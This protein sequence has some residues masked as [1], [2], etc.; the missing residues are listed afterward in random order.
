MKRAESR[1]DRHHEDEQHH[2]RNDPGETAAADGSTDRYLRIGV[3]L[4]HQGHDQTRD[5]E[6]EG[7][8]GHVGHQNAGRLAA[9]GGDACADPEQQRNSIPGRAH[10]FAW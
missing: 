6:C 7:A 8:D 10:C 4:G 3:V 2:D 9:E 1:E 5:A